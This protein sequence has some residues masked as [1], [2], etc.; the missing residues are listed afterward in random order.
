MEI[1]CPS[2]LV[3]YLIDETKIKTNRLSVRC[4]KCQE[5]IEI[6]KPLGSL[7]LVENMPVL[8]GSKANSL[9]NQYLTACRFCGGEI[10]ADAIRCVHCGSILNTPAKLGL[11]AYGRSGRL[12][13]HDRRE[14]PRTGVGRKILKIGALSLVGIVGLFFTI[15]FV[16]Y[17]LTGKEG[18]VRL[19]NNMEAYAV[20]Y[21]ADHKIL[22]RSEEIIAYYD[23]TLSLNGTESAILTTE[24]IIYHKDGLDDFIRLDD[25]IEIKHRK[26]LAGDLI[27]IYGSSGK[28]IL[29]EIAPLN[30]GE[31]FLNALIHAVG[32]DR[33]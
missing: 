13:Y 29:V 30:Q 15:S 5:I 21:I 8:N 33:S 7:D 16:H 23:V 19:Q 17:A 22:N 10:M 20:N 14:V 2:C 18:G 3:T 24:R 4:P 32:F 26:E 25:V 6:E 27:E 12:N 1:Q 31:T 11:S 9:Q 28:V